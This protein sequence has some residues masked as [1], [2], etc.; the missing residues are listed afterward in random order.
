M[1][2][3]EPI[4]QEAYDDLCRRSLSKVPGDLARLIYLASTREYNTGKYHHDG[5]AARY[6]LEAAEQ[7]LREA[8]RRTF[9]KIAT[10]ALEELVQQLQCYVSSTSRGPEEI[11]RAWQKLEP[12]RVAL[13]MDVHPVLARFFVS[14]VRLAVAILQHRETQQS[15]RSA[16]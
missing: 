9:E 2:E 7:A 10:C 15:H 8:H 16:A 13:P 3:C 1:T 5:L 4:L 14:N 6:G 12:Y 11:L